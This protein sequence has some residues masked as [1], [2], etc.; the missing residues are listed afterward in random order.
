MV[1]TKGQIGFWAGKKRTYKNPKERNRK[2]SES[3]RG[4]KAW[5]WKGEK[6]SY[7]EKH[8]WIRKWYGTPDICE[9]CKKAGLKGSKIHWAN[10]TGKYK[11]EITDWIRLCAKCHLAYDRN[12][13]E[14][15]LLP[16]LMF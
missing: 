16:S 10:K 13:L 14:L 11:R 6:A 3:M 5:Q 12:K 8:W 4:E 1:F 7:I 9:I 2:I 15:K